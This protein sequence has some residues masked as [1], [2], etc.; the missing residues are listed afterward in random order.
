MARAGVFAFGVIAY[1]QAIRAE[2]VFELV[3][4]ASAFGSAGILVTAVFGLFTPLGG[5]F[6]ALAT[7]VGGLVVYLA[8][9]FGGFAYPYLLSLA[10]SLLTYV[11]VGTMERVATRMR[12]A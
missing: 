3:E 7:L 5:P 1:V 4:S 8:A 2:G 9:T 10:V 12:H 6:A 11:V